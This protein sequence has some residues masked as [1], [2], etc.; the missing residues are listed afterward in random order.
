EIK[1]QALE[2]MLKELSEEHSQTEDVIHNW[3][4]DQDDS[5]LFTGVLKKDRTISGSIAYCASQA[6]KMTKTGNVAMVDDQTVFGWVR[7][8]FIKDKI[9]VDPADAKA[10]VAAAEKPKKQP[11]RKKRKEEK[12]GEEQLSLFDFL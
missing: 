1:K 7:E 2:K 9:E 8:Y 6:R 5:Q 12:E 3:L 11:K 10:T 4:C